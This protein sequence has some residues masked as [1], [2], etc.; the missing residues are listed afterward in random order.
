MA[1][2]APGTIV[3]M[4]EYALARDIDRPVGI[5]LAAGGFLTV[6]RGVD[7]A[8]RLPERVLRSLFITFLVVAAI[9]LGLKAF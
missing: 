4:I 7:L 3:A 6:S 1:L 9:A 5:A 2:V 8:H